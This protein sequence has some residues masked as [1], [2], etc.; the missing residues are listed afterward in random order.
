[1]RHFP[2][3]MAFLFGFA[4]FAVPALGAAIWFRTYEVNST[5]NLP[6][7]DRNAGAYAMA[8]DPTL[9][10]LYVGGFAS[11]SPTMWH[12]EKRDKA[13]GKLVED[14]GSGGILEERQ[15]SDPGIFTRVAGIAIDKA[16]QSIYVT[17]DEYSFNTYSALV[18]HYDRYGTL[19]S[20]TSS[21]VS[22]R[23][24]SADYSPNAISFERLE[25]RFFGILLRTEKV[26]HV[27]GRYFCT[28]MGFRCG[29]I[30]DSGF[31]WRLQ[32]QVSGGVESFTE[33]YRQHASGV[34]DKMVYRAFAFGPDGIFLVG[35]RKVASESNRFEWLVEKRDPGNGNLCAG[36]SA[37]GGVAFDGDG[38][39]GFNVASENDEALAVMVSP[40][41]DVFI[42]GYQGPQGGIPTSHLRIEKRSGNIGRLALGFDS[43]GIVRD[44]YHPNITGSGMISG[45]TIT[46]DTNDSS[47]NV[48]GYYWNPFVASSRPFWFS[49]KWDSTTG[50]TLQKDFSSTKGLGA[51]ALLIE[52]NNIYMTGSA[53]ND[54]KDVIR[55]ERAKTKVEARDPVRSQ[56]IG[57]LQKA[58]NEARKEYAGVSSYSF[59]RTP[60]FGDLVKKGDVNEILNSLAFYC[61]VASDV[62]TGEAVSAT[63]FNGI[64]EILKKL[65]SKTVAGLCP[66]VNSAHSQF[67]C[68]LGGGEIVVGD[69]G[70]RFCR[71]SA[72][73]C[74]SGWNQYL[75]WSETPSCHRSFSSNICNGWSP[76]SC[77]SR[78]HAWSDS[79]E[80]NCK[81]FPGGTNWEQSRS[82]VTPDGQYTCSGGRESC[83]VG[84]VEADGLSCYNIQKG[85]T[86]VPS[87]I[88]C[89]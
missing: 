5:L 44:Y 82:S 4:L 17:G 19:L 77:T 18:H 73:S 12:I 28:T 1:M 38:L 64:N 21:Y 29:G 49:G 40:Q 85:C 3:K 7:L 87:R 79:A 9:S 2:A 52:G 47:V 78:S 35:S 30:F 22:S 83:G 56:H 48:A 51:N 8:S 53:N 24:G 45:N 88:G 39:A 60:V 32:T 86:S 75:N 15:S 81:S 46:F 23:H 36:G 25:I 13:T 74:P 66:L 34:D 11:T 55:L 71:F 72:S 41:N 62:S 80:N 59:P 84:G 10:Y 67:D 27:A 70:A 69:A 6:S 37:C 58:A 14:F 89:Y 76:N 54:S 57:D 20:A 63:K 68:T 42:A 26:T 61:S 31:L 16:D 33:D 50:A 65:Q 43:D